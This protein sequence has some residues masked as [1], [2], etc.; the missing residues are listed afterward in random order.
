MLRYQ[1]PTKRALKLS[2]SVASTI[3]GLN[4]C[5][6]IPDDLLTT[7]L[8]TGEAD[9]NKKFVW[10]PLA[11]CNNNNKT[12]LLRLCGTANGRYLGP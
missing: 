3:N 2:R 5:Q 11:N 4:G 10:L 9:N 7:E 12:T 1:C 6:S 8:V